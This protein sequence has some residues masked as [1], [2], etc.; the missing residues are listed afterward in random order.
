MGS[1]RADCRNPAEPVTI[2]RLLRKHFSVPEES[3]SVLTDRSSVPGEPSSGTSIR[4]GT[5]FFAT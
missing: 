1:S 4:Q 2:Y 5:S 3:S